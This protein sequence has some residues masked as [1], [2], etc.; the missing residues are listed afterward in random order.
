MLKR[1]AGC[2]VGIW[3][4]P[5]ALGGLGAAYKVGL[6][7]TV[8]FDPWLEP[9]H[10]YGPPMLA[11]VVL[12]IGLAWFAGGVLGIREARFS[13]RIAFVAAA[14]LIF[15]YSFVRAIVVETAFTQRYA[16]CCC[17]MDVPTNS[18]TYARVFVP[19]AF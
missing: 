16:Y 17:C 7:K 12:S 18:E 8:G 2:A 3:L 10:V 9:F 13:R 19:Y 1:A 5:I 15:M 14:F 6:F 4:G 11:Y